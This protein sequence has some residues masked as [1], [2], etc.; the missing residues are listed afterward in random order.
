MDAFLDKFNSQLLNLSSRNLDTY[1]FTDS[2]IN[3]LNLLTDSSSRSYFNTFTERGFTL[4]NL[5]ATRIQGNSSTLIDHIITNSNAPAMLSGSII[6]DISDHFITFL[7]PK[8]GKVKS[9]PQHVARRI[10]SSANI[11]NCQSP[12][13]SN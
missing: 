1:I 9:K 6:D 10:H 12:I 3:L 2:N 7:S 13:A 5:K 8:L 4:T 11:A